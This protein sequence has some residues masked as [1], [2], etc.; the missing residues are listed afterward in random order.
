MIWVLR[1]ISTKR[2]YRAEAMLLRGA[3]GAMVL[4]NFQCWGILLTWIIVG[5]RPI[6]LAVGGGCLNICSLA[7]H[8]SFHFP[9]LWETI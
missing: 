6:V 8:F 5:Q 9:S 2:L 4:G 3:F 7:S 1:H